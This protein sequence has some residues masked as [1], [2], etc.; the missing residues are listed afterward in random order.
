MDA[1]TSALV[2]EP[3]FEKAMNDIVANY[4]RAWTDYSV[5]QVIIRPGDITD[6]SATFT[7]RRASRVV[8]CK[9]EFFVSHGFRRLAV[10]IKREYPSF[11]YGEP[12]QV[13]LLS[14]PTAHYACRLVRAHIKLAHVIVG[15]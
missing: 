14:D 9:V 12:M 15:S 10:T 3:S 8:R 4:T 2:A 1:L 11:P 6:D 7:H 13:T 5:E